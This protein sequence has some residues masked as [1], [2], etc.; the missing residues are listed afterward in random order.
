MCPIILPVVMLGILQITAVNC[1]YIA[2]LFLEF[3]T[4]F[5][6]FFFFIMNSVEFNGLLIKRMAPDSI[7]SISLTRRY[8]KDCILR[9]HSSTFGLL[10]QICL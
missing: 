8:L 7:A 1:E 6:F 5:F 3:H 4:F 9:I 2:E 10:V